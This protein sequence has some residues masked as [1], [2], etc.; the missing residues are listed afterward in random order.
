M[1]STGTYYKMCGGTTKY[2]GYSMGCTGRCS[3]TTPISIEIN[4]LHMCTTHTHTQIM[5]RQDN[6]GVVPISV[7]TSKVKIVF[8]VHIYVFYAIIV[9]C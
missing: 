8:G 1:K 2:M 7:L 4:F 6:M 9:V 3:K 5:P